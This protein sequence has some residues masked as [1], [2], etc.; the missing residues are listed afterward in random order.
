MEL[1]KTLH[2]LS[3]ESFYEFRSLNEQDVTVSYID[4]LREQTKYL[5]NVP[6]LINMESQKE[7]IRNILLNKTDVICGLFMNG[8]LVGTAGIQYSLSEIFVQSFQKQIDGLATIGIFVFSKKHRGVGLGKSL[9]WA[10]VMLLH[11]CCETRWFGAEMEKENTPSL[12]SFL[13]CGFD[14][15]YSD[16][17]KYKVLLEISNIVKPNICR[18]YKVE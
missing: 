7:H 17:K 6:S 10:S 14:R 9:V 2:Y 4:G 12:N 16:H 13:S 5:K 3:G 18:N 15:V 11:S 1:N 8:E